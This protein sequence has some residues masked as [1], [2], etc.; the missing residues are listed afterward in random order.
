MLQNECAVSWDVDFSKNY[1]INKNIAFVCLASKVDSHIDRL[2]GNGKKQY[3]KMDL[4]IAS[5]IFLNYRKTL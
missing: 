3:N 2:F 1:D 4:K 5:L